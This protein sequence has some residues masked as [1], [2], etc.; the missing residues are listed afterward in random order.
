[1]FLFDSPPPLIFPKPAILRPAP[2]ELLQP[3]KGL[4]G[5]HV[6]IVGWARAAGLVYVGGQNAAHLGGTTT[7]TNPFNLTGGVGPADPLAGDLVI[8]A[9]GVGSTSARNP[10][11]SITGYTELADVIEAGD[12]NH[13]N[14]G[15]FYKYL[16][17]DEVNYERSGTGNAA[18]GGATVVQV[19]R[20]A[21][22]VPV[23]EGAGAS[24]LNTSRVVP[25]SVAS[26][27]SGAQYLFCGAGATAAGAAFTSGDLSDFQ[28]NFG[29]DTIDGVAGIGNLAGTGGTINPAAWGGPGVNAADSWICRVVKVSPA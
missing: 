18:D 3:K 7:A 9:F 1:M 20:G 10:D 23:L 27:V 24:G 21:N 14:L 8:I 26:S 11:L 12:T 29:A 13:A 2:A 15:V 16:T 28:T 6:P 22:S 17:V 5:F 25:P 4:I 19:W